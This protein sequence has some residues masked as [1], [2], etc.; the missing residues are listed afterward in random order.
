V[1]KMQT[2]QGKKIALFT[3]DF[4]HLTIKVMEY[5]TENNIDLSLIIIE[6]ATPGKL[7]QTVIQLNEAHRKYNEI[8]SKRGKRKN[9]S[10]RLKKSLRNLWESLPTGL[11]RKLK[12]LFIYIH[13]M[14][15][16]S[17]RKYAKTLGIPIIVVKRHSSKKTRA[18]LEEHNISYVLRVASAGLIKKTL[19]TM[20]NTK[21]INVHCAKL[22]QHRSL[23]ALPWSVLEGDKIGLTAHF[24]DAGIDTGLILYFMEVKPEPGDNL[25]TLRQ[26]VDSK[27]PEIFHKVI[28]GLMDGSIVPIEQQISDG[29]HHRP[30]TVE[31]LLL[32]DK[33]LQD[34]F[35]NH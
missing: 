9:L 30:M 29:V 7:P 10:F 1:E 24:I 28:N 5:L 35:R 4:H 11:R 33:T 8:I 15:K 26:R 2:T 21:I 25:N 16:R 13:K 3:R 18:A 14:N 19:L 6:T 20:K 34:R 32:A 17:V 22:P 23:D 31:E 12:P 27:Q